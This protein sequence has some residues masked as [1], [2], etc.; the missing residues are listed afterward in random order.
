MQTQAIV[1]PPTDLHQGAALLKRCRMLVSNDG[2]INHLAVTTET[3][4]LAIFGDTDPVVWS[5]ASVFAHHHHLYN[6]E[7][8]PGSDRTFG[9]S[10]EAAFAEVL[11]ILGKRDEL[12]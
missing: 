2:G 8:R 5:P 12:R 7:S 4:T 11:R 10:A 1:A 3:E 6:P 9:V